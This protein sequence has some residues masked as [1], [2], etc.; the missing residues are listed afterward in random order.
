MKFIFLIQRFVSVKVEFDHGTC[1]CMSPDGKGYILI[2]ENN[3]TVNVYKI[4]KKDDGKITGQLTLQF[5]EVCVYVCVRGETVYLYIAIFTSAIQYNM[6]TREYQYIINRN[7]L[8]LT[9][10]FY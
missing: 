8:S 4:T 3:Q 7:C 1:C 6:A 9:L 10:C 5:P 2:Q